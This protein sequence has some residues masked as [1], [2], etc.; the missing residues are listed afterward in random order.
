MNITTRIAGVATLAL[1]LLPVVSLSVAQA[2]APVRLHPAALTPA[3]YS[4]TIGTVVRR[5]CGDEKRLS[6]R[7]ACESAV[8]TEAQEKLAMRIMGTQVAA[9]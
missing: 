9:R 3:A 1:A 8:R 4:E 6:E 7:A 5:F 2:A